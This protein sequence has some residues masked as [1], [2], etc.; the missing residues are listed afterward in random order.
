MADYTILFTKLTTRAQLALVILRFVIKMLCGD[1]SS[2][3]DWFGRA[4][5]DAFLLRASL[6]FQQLH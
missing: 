2:T 4:L 3:C 6:P 1:V 5:S